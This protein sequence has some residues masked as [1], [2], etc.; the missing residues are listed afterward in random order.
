MKQFHLVLY[1][2]SIFAFKRLNISV[3][4]A[5][6]SLALVT[7]EV[8]VFSQSVLYVINGGFIIN[9]YDSNLVAHIIGTRQYIRGL[10]N[11]V[12]RNYNSEKS[13]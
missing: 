2:S 5:P 3:L 8:A 7:M 12:T 1:V 11:F 6:S 9:A 10:C 4:L 13:I